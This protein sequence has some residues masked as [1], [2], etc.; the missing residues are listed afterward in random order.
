MTFADKLNE[1]LSSK[2]MTAS[3]LAQLSGIAPSAICQYRQ[4]KNK[5]GRDK[6]DAM[7]TALDVSPEELKPDTFEGPKPEPGDVPFRFST[8]KITTR[9][10]ASIMH[11]ADKDL[12]D[13]MEAGECDFGYCYGTDAQGKRRFYINPKAFYEHT[14]FRYET[15]KG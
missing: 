15:P 2:H 9:K 6:I 1:L 4:G 7:A 8:K 13:R 11:M 14:G 3:R 12:R 5:P 10:A